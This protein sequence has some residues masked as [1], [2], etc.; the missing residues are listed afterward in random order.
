MEVELAAIAHVVG[1]L[2]GEGHD[3]TILGRIVE[4][5]ANMPCRTLFLRSGFEAGAGEPGFFVL[6]ATQSPVAVPRVLAIA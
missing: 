6:S 4:T 3:P 2:R 1:A 5:E